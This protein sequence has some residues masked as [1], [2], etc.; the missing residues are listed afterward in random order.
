MMAVV[1]DWYFLRVGSQL[2]VMLVGSEGPG[3][4]L[5]SRL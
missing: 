1:E 3:P 5:Q 4:V 2:E